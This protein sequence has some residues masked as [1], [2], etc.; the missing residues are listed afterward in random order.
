MWNEL[1]RLH[2]AMSE[3][4]CAPRLGSNIDIPEGSRYIQVSDTLI[5]QLNSWTTKVVQNDDNDIK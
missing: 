4:N 5:K 1:E 3:L 2:A